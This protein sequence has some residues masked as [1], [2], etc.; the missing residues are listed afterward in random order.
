LPNLLPKFPA[1][2]HPF[3]KSIHRFMADSPL[4]DDALHNEVLRMLSPP[5]VPLARFY[6]ESASGEHCISFRIITS[7]DE[8][9]EAGFNYRKYRMFIHF[10]ALKMYIL[11]GA[12][13]VVVIVG[14]PFFMHTSLSKPVN[15][16]VQGLEKVASGDLDIAIPVVIEDEIGF[17]TRSFNTMVQSIRLA[18]QERAIA[19]DS[20]RLAEARFRGIVEHSLA[21]IY[22]I[23]QG[24]FVYVNPTFANIF[25]YTV[26]EILELPSALDIVDPADRREVAHS[27]HTRESSQEPAMKYAYRGRKKDGTIVHIESLGTSIE[28]GGNIAVMGTVLDV[29]QSR[30]TRLALIQEKERLLIT[31]ASIGDGVIA[32]DMNGNIT[33]INHVAQELTGWEFHEAIGEKIET[34]YQILEPSTLQPCPNATDIILQEGEKPVFQQRVLRCRDGSIRFISERGTCMRDNN[35]MVMG[36]VL[37]FHDI[38]EEKKRQNELARMRLLLKRMIDSM[39]SILIGIDS[40]EKIIYW[41]SQAETFTGSNEHDVSGKHVCDVL[42]FLHEHLDVIRAAGSESISRKVQQIQVEKNG[43]LLH[44]EMVAYPLLAADMEGMVIRLDDVTSRLRMEEMIIQTE[45]MVSL[46]GLAAGMAHEINNPLGGIMMGSQNILRRIDPNHKKNRD[47]ASNCGIEIEKIQEYMEKRGIIAILQGILEMG[48]RAS[49]IVENMLSFS[50]KSESSKSSADLKALTEKAIELASNEYDLKKKFDFRHIEIVREY[51]DDIPQIACVKTEIQQVILNLLKN[52][53]YAVG[54]KNYVDSH[55]R[56]TIRLKKEG[57][58]IRLDVSDNGIGM[59]SETKKRVFEPFFTTK[60]AGMGTGLG[61]SVS[62]FI[63]TN[64]HGGQMEVDSLHGIG[65]TFTVRLPM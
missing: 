51:D 47:F 1:E 21:G 56:I 4:P 31:L 40:E 9:Y 7:H 64:N 33:L 53:A 6:S 28:L 13:L 5:V 37:V 3:A 12:L 52:A 17:L 59:D 30:R 8:L 11:L 43:A 19:E 49:G 39:P 48:E 42:P 45:K 55:P 10:S 36:V 15:N 24:K 62:Y 50:R 54:K 38:T 58:M 14:I 63:I 23:Q 46:G 35:N 65:T 41:N 20:L 60:E 26:E 25:G 27:I 29:T 61:L 16:L 44:F 18:N 22:V 32:V 34:I 2:F 57:Q